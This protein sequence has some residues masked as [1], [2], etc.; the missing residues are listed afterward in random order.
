MNYRKYIVN[1]EKYKEVNLYH[2]GGIAKINIGEESYIMMGRRL[3]S[4]I[5]TLI[6]NLNNGQGSKNLLEFYMLHKEE[7][8]NIEILE[9]SNESSDI[10]K[11]KKIEYINKFQAKLNYHLGINGFSEKHKAAISKSKIGVNHNRAKLNE[12]KA[13]KIKK[14]ALE[15]NLSSTQIGKMFDISPSQVRKIKQGTAWSHLT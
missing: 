2:K 4:D 15:S 7:K 5:T 12:A 10:M 14:L 1:L 9:I 6:I 13:K 3:L 11:Q 8:F